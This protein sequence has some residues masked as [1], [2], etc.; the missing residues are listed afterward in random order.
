[1]K[2]RLTLKEILDIKLEKLNEVFSKIK[3]DNP[4]DFYVKTRIREKMVKLKK[5]RENL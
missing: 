2:K 4:L 1:M 3:S 5:Q